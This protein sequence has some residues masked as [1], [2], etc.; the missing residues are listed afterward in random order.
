VSNSNRFP[1]FPAGRL[2][3]VPIPG[4]FFSELVPVIDDLPE[5]KVTLHV[6]WLISRG[7]RPIG[8]VTLGEL[9]KDPVLVRGLKVLDEDPFGLLARALNRAVERGTLLRARTAGEGES[10]AEWFFLNT[11]S[12]RDLFSRVRRGEVD[13]GGEVLPGEEVV[14]EE[15]PNIF[16]L[17]EQNVGLLQPLIVEELEEAETLYPMTWIEEA[18]KIAVENNARNWRYI[19]A[20]LERWRAEGKSNEEHGRDPREDG[21][22]YLRGR[23]TDFIKH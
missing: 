4:L 1:G 8:G 5:L 10:T 23:H 22:S 2:K 17:Y 6:F 9:R 14:P 18:F 21:Q 16:V 7:R 19:R 15:R 3:A 13:L 12:G 20:I 11:E